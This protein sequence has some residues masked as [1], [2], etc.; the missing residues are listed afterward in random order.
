M[1]IV[2]I[3]IMI[4][5]PACINLL[6]IDNKNTKRSYESSQGQQ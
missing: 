4:I 1:T 6:K 5:I 2:V 3:I